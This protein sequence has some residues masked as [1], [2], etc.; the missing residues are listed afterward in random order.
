[1]L[2]FKHMVLLTDWVSFSISCS[3]K[4]KT[5][6]NTQQSSEM[7][8]IKINFPNEP[9]PVSVPLSVASNWRLTDVRAIGNTVFF[10][11]GDTTLSTNLAEYERL[12]LLIQK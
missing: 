11:V 6:W 10:K 1:M 7:E 4:L 2:G 3:F 8:V 9:F 5:A 12:I